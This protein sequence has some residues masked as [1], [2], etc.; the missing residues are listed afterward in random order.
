VSLPI[1]RLFQ[2]L[3]GAPRVASTSFRRARASR[4]TSQRATA[5]LGAEPLEA[6]SML[7]VT[8]SLSA[9]TSGD[10]IV[11]QDAVPEANDIIEVVLSKG[12]VVDPID[13][14][15]SKIVDGITVNATTAAG[16]PFA[17]GTFFPFLNPFTGAVVDNVEILQQQNTTTVEVND[18]IGAVKIVD[19]VGAA[20]QWDT[21][22]TQTGAG[23]K[24]I[25]V[26]NT[27][28]NLEVFSNSTVGLTGNF[29][30]GNVTLETAGIKV[31][32]AGGPGVS[33]GNLVLN[34]AAAG[35]GAITFIDDL[36]AT[37]SLQ[38]KT[39][40]ALVV[41]TD[42]TANAMDLTL[43]AGGSQAGGSL[44][45]IGASPTF[46][47]VAGG[48]VAFEST[49]NSL[50]EIQ[51][52]KAAGQTVAIASST[53]ITQAAAGILEAQSL[54]VRSDASVTLDNAANDVDSLGLIAG[55]SVTFVDTDELVL[56]VGL[57]GVSAGTNSV[58]I[59]TSGN[60]TQAATGQVVAGV[61]TATLNAPL[62]GNANLIL[63]NAN[64]QISEFIAT[65]AS[66]GGGVTIVNTPS[67]LPLII[68]G[69]TTTNGPVS[70]TNGT[71][72]EVN[73][74]IN[75]GAGTVTLTSSGSIT[76]AAVITAGSLVA[77]NNDVAGAIA[78]GSEANVVRNV[79]LRNNANTPGS[80]GISFKGSS[81][82]TGA[83]T[84]GV[85]G[86][87]LSAARGNIE[88]D[89][90]G[91]PL[92][93]NAGI[94]T[95]LEGDV[96]LTATGGITQPSGAGIVADELNVINST[97][98]A[99]ILDSSNNDVG[100]LAVTAGGKVVYTD[101]TDLS[102]K[103]GGGIVAN[104]S[105]TLSVGGTF[106]STAGNVLS[107]IGATGAVSVTA[108][109]T[110]TLGD[111]VTAKSGVDVT[112][113]TASSVAAIAIKA[114]IDSG[115]GQAI[116]TAT[117]GISSDA[118]GTIVGGTDVSLVGPTSVTLGANVT[119]TNGALT[120]TSSG[121]GVTTNAGAAL[122]SAAGSVDVTTKGAA[123][124]GGA[125]NALTD[126]T[127]VADGTSSITIDGAFNAGGDILLAAT[128]AIVTT[129]SI[130][131]GSVAAASSASMTIGGKIS[132]LLGAIDMAAGGSFT[133][134]ITTADL[135]AAG[136]I[137]VTSV[138][139]M[140]LT[141]GATGAQVTLT[142]GDA[143]AAANI[144]LKDAILATAGSAVITATGGSLTTTTGGTITA[145]GGD[146]VL[147]AP[148]GITLADAVAGVVVSAAA[149]NG[150]VKINAITAGS[151]ATLDAANG[152]TQTG[153]ITA[154]AL[155]ARNTAAG[156]IVLTNG[157]NAVAVFEASNAA[158]GQS[159][160]LVNAA[161]LTVGSLGVTTVN[162]EILINNDNGGAGGT[163]DLAGVIN[164]G[165]ADVTLR[166]AGDMNQINT[167]AITAAN[168]EL[169]SSGGD[170]VLESPTNDVNFL[171]GSTNGGKLFFQDA[172][173]LEIA[174]P[175]TRPIKTNNGDVG[176]TSGGVLTIGGTVD[177]GAGDITLEATGGITGLSVHALISGG[178]VSLA[179][180]GSGN[181]VTTNPGNSFPQLSAVSPSGTTID[182][183]SNQGV[184]IVGSGI[185]VA[186]GTIQLQ[187]DGAIT[188]S[189]NIE[190]RDA[191][192]LST[193]AVTLALATNDVDNLA[194]RATGTVDFIDTDDLAIGV[195]GN[196]I[197]TVFADVTLI[198]GKALTLNNEVFAGRSGFTGGVTLS[199]AAGAGIRQTASQLTADDL[200]VT[201]TT[202]DLVQLAQT[203]NEFDR[204]AL[205]T[206]GNA[207]IV[208]QT[209]FETGVTRGA[210]P[211]PVEVS[212]FDLDL[213]TAGPFSRLRVVSGLSYAVTISNIPGLSAL[214]LK[215]GDS[216]TG[217][218]LVEFVPTNEFDNTMP[219]FEGTL[220]D[221]IQYANDNRAT[222]TINGATRTQPQ[223]V[224]FDQPG[225]IVDDNL[226]TSA[227]PAIVRPLSFDGARSNTGRVGIDGSGIASTATINGLVYN[228]GSNNSTVN[229]MALYGFATGAGIQLKSAVNAITN[230]FLGVERDGL[231][232]NA[233]K[234]GV[235]LTG[236]TATSNTI[237][238][239]VV[240]ETAANVIGGNTYAGVVV[241][242]GATANA[243]VG[244]FIGTD[245]TLAPNLGN[246]QFGIV[247]DAVNGNFVGSRNAVRPD[248][249][250]A[251]SNVIANNNLTG[252]AIVNA[253]AATSK[254]GNL[255]ENNLIDANAIHGIEVVNSTFQT[256]GGIQARQAN[257]VTNQAVGAGIAVVASADI[258]LAAN[259][260]GV[261]SVGSVG[262]G[263]ALAGVLV[264]SSVRTVINAGNRIGSNGRG[265]WLAKGSTGNRVEGNFIGTNE[266]GAIL[267]NAIEGVLI[268]R[269]IGN[270]VRLGNIINNNG[271]HGV[272]L[273][274]ATAAT[275]AAGNVVAGNNIA[276][277][278]YALT[279]GG[280]GVAISGGARHTI[281]GVGVGNVI[282]SNANEGILVNRS[283]LTGSSV[284]VVIQGNYLG[285]NA[286]S[287]IS[288]LLGNRVGIRLQQ[289]NTAT[290]DR[291]NVILNN[292]SD[293]I[294]LEGTSLVTLGSTVANAG[295]II[296][297]NGGA[298]VTITD[299][300]LAGSVSN[301]GNN[302][303]GNTITNNTGIGIN[304]VGTTNAQGLSTTSNVVIGT[305]AVPGRVVGGQ[306]N[307]IANN[308]GAGVTIDGAQGVTVEGNSV[309]G[310]VGLPIDIK[311]NGN[312]GAISPTL[313]SAVFTQ[314][315]KSTGQIAVQGTLA[316]PPTAG[317]G[318]VTVLNGVATFTSKQ[319]LAA[320]SLITIGG[321]NY[322]VAAAVTNGT[323]ARLLGNPTVATT[324]AGAVSASRGAATFS[325]P[326]SPALVG[327]T[328]IVAGR[329]YTV[330]SLSA[331][332]RTGVIT[333]APTFGVSSFS[334]LQGNTFSFPSTASLN[335]Q[336]VVDVY[337]NLPSDGNPTTGVG[338]GMRTFLG[339]ATVTVGPTGS[340]AFSLTVNLPLGQVPVG[341]Y[342]TA[343]ATTVRPAANVSAFSTSQVSSRA[344]EVVFATPTTFSS[345]T[346]RT[347]R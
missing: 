13:P 211:L 191:T 333:G 240:D 41:A 87:G 2:S 319:T 214:S 238:T 135:D 21:T 153:S 69:I 172:D 75:A 189:K 327:Q 311:N 116:F 114:A 317:V 340:G 175:I 123:A 257:V 251:A 73:G 297:Q 30:A 242:N 262:L 80:N 10:I 301:S 53:A 219:F 222:Q 163:L 304:V 271:S 195:G 66:A 128:N 39:N 205:A 247:L 312:L 184:E 303:F 5:W 26:Q 217:V 60:L 315:S 285:T 104:D 278:G 36:T 287:E 151:E 254:L 186:G 261:D 335:Q 332:G 130:T 83:L 203:A 96:S 284:G 259:Y 9:G 88:I 18:Q 99:V 192:F 283:G 92:V 216:A 273:T 29:G 76:Q 201:N 346:R 131:G 37:G 246:S 286:N 43:N 48:A 248:G 113:G 51:D 17:S 230:T 134:T 196:G 110:V 245:S 148:T 210:V 229:G 324:L 194:I 68:G 213:S 258:S 243:I 20:T 323:Q 81:P 298:G 142:A 160:K 33:G 270:F 239:V 250:A 56:G 19:G 241:R 347:R 266:A 290:I 215:A 165:T 218:G 260:I 325:V 322:T 115:T 181:I 102:L 97:S 179:N 265:V 16:S 166:S 64:N 336:Y 305:S 138:G 197:R 171:F 156:G 112:A 89:T 90:N 24:V 139:A 40:A 1:A 313:T 334:Q 182:V 107:V 224:V 221:M 306:V 47:L 282:T 7:A 143:S 345:T 147:V 28:S 202:T 309:F 233:N 85:G 119:A 316:A 4:S 330:T 144:T 341:S 127:V 164:A 236:Q 300:V 275:T 125:V 3:V 232:I 339:R 101:A 190:S 318:Q 187:A 338:Y 174:A 253:K 225:Y 62:S 198:A 281:G 183:K 67:A 6:R 294:S 65:N 126:I 337:L 79:A 46:N 169:S 185:Q 111:A 59:T 155:L 223:T 299:R 296:S 103:A 70:I 267:G 167:A 256:I 276:A 121:G 207:R 274:D 77:V 32:N 208:E 288:S 140:S 293:G 252:V 52:L 15:K 100:N 269:S 289:A 149:A 310:N 255:I 58:S 42:V 141:G 329:T 105:I 55:G 8:I 93:I 25:S 71:G 82:A 129:A 343:T 50:G 272:S 137:L 78:L 180:N 44:G 38:I 45:T 159:I 331:N 106:T 54:R 86:V 161:N 108:A 120:V 23:A 74:A 193:G 344:R 57:V 162:G 209:G 145:L 228:A 235:E 220:R 152:I 14:T 176:I 264:D 12:T 212:A 118:A 320:N 170:I 268:D 204:L 49:A 231:T 326:Q 295:N 150:A 302:V 133:S 11:T 158:S 91:R 84:I 244:N 35:T 173:A 314:N 98:G 157:G 109:G 124:F 136:D 206:L 168:L 279:G 22:Y 132:A 226:L 263:N 237:G 249:T 122:T 94:T 34:T 200:I 292:S 154:P 277:N 31:G 227:L 199:M 307:T 72:I 234:I 321:T 95:A 178:T 117:G 342:L 146:A 177:A 328:I 61:F 188:Q 291:R 27:P 280:A 308:G 63:G